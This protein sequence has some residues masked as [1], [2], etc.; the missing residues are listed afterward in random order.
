VRD[1]AVRIECYTLDLDS[2]SL[3][4]EDG[5]QVGVRVTTLARA[6]NPVPDR[7]LQRSPGCPWSHTSGCGPA[8]RPESSNSSTSSATLSPGCL[9][10]FASLSGGRARAFAQTGRSRASNAGRLHYILTAALPA[11]LRT[12]C[13]H[14]GAAWTPTRVLGPEIPDLTRDGIRLIVLRQRIAK[15]PQRGGKQLLEVPGSRF[16]PL[17]INQPVRSVRSKVGAATMAVPKSGTRSWNWKH[18]LA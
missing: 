10:P 2:F 15:R 7:L 12:L 13:Y 6:S 18:C 17:R 8:I 16:Q 5:H 4:H 3:P 9:R 14:A 1:L 11:L